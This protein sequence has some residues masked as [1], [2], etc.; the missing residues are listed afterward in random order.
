FVTRAGNFEI[1]SPYLVRFPGLT[2]IAAYAGRRT[3]VFFPFLFSTT[4][5]TRLRLPAGRIVKR[6]PT[7]REFT[8]PGMTASTHHEL[9]RDGDLQVLVVKRSVNVSRREIPVSEYQSLRDFLSGLMQE[10]SK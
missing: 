9:T 4:S 2:R 1:V 6:I 3:P 10:E 7:D 8:G 5:E